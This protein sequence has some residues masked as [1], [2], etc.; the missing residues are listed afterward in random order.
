MMQADELLNYVKEVNRRLDELQNKTAIYA[1][2]LK[3]Y[4]KKL[5]DNA[6]SKYLDVKKA[7]AKRIIDESKP[8]I[9]KECEDIR[10][11]YETE[12]Q[13]IES[14]FKNNWEILKDAV[15]QELEKKIEG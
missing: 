14:V 1:D 12:V 3:N 15:K 11:K 6:K 5:G 4:A 10:K 8:V 9:E 7:E 13:H 2:E